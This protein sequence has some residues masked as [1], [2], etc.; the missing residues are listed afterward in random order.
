MSAEYIIYADESIKQGRYFSNFYG[1]V[2]VRS[3]D[4]DRVRG[5]L[6]AKKTEL[7]CFGEVKWERV[8]SNYLEKYQSLINTFFDLVQQDIVK[9]RIM[10]T[11]NAIVPE[12]LTAEQRANEFQLLYYQFIKHA[13]GLKYS[14]ETGLPIR[15]RLYLDRIPDTQE[16]VA[17]FKGYLAGLNQSIDFQQAQIRI[18][19]EQIAEVDSSDHSILQCLDIVLGSM[20]FR[21]NDMHRETLPHSRRRGRRT[22]AKAN[23]YQTIST[24]IRQIYPNF[25]I[26]ITTGISGSRANRWLHP[27][28]H[29]CFRPREFRRD[30]TR[31]KDR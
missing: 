16:K 25:N 12:G 27:Y 29:W 30:N 1:G 14:N 23:M 4:V 31:F 5:L 28:R 21:L 17:I 11:Q 19:E 8:T 26:G 10:F 18:R 2:L 13:F 22:V 15:L 7:H 9:V 6:D 20:Q 24:R 3:R